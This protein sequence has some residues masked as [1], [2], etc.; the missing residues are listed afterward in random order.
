MATPVINETYKQYSWKWLDKLR[1][2]QSAITDGPIKSAKQRAWVGNYKIKI[3]ELV[4]SNK[5]KPSHKITKL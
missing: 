1:K 3:E 4:G 5:L 2:G